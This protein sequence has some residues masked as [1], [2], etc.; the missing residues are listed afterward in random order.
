MTWIFAESAL[1]RGG[2]RGAN[3]GGMVA[4]VVDHGDAVGRAS[5][6]EATIDAAEVFE[7]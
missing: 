1:A 3:L 2:Q 5:Q 7:R 4:V 6:L